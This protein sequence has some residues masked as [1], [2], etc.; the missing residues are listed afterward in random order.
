MKET[1]KVVK[2]GEVSQTWFSQGHDTDHHMTRVAAS[3]TC[4]L[5]SHLHTDLPLPCLPLP[6]LSWVYRFYKNMLKSCFLCRYRLR[7][8]RQPPVSSDTAT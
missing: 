4:P 3:Q 1:L 7:V 6:F 8:S 2:L 5:E